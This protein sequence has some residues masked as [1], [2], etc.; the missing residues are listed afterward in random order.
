[1]NVQTAQL[2]PAMGE[3][4][5][6]N[7]LLGDQKALAD[8]WERDGYWFFRDVLDQDAIG[9]IRK[10]YQDYLVEMGVADATDPECRYNGADY[11]GLPINSN[12]TKLNEA[13]VHRML[14][15]SPAINAFF[16]R[17]F[18]CDP[19]WVPI[20]VHRTNPPVQERGR[21]RFDFIHDDGV[22][23]E[24]L[25]FL[26]CWVPIGDID[27]DVGGLA[28]VE[29]MSR[30]P[31]LHRREGMKINPIQIEDVP[32]GQW[33]HTHYRPGD[34]LLMDLRTPHS[35]ISNVSAERFRLSMDT[36]I[37]PS[38]GNVPIV[39]A[40]T[41]VSAQSVSVADA[42]GV[43]RLNFDANS[44]VRGLRGDQMPLADVPARYAA[45]DDVIVTV[46]GDRV[47]NMRPQT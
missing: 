9:A 3:L 20:T 27:A 7:E 19:F 25:P 31:T 41:E 8:A 24:G 32:E 39:G 35:G 12:V 43:H 17:L 15:E 36:R 23:N 10:V 21:S 26:I 11:S 6:H 18:G 33:R 2:M 44:F 28:L 14:H 13:K 38:S 40:L 34:V 1:M 37:M 47:V 5:C 29:G 45:G 22:Y 30:K 16:T 42:K 46:D 4:T